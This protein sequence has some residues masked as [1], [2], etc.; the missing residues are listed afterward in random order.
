MVSCTM[1][2]ILFDM[3]EPVTESV[4]FT[5]RELKRNE[6]G[7]YPAHQT[8]GPDRGYW[9][10]E[11]QP[12]PTHRRSMRICATE[13]QQAFGVTR[14]THPHGFVAVLSDHPTPAG[15][16]LKPDAEELWQVWIQDA[17]SEP[18][19]VDHMVSKRVK[20]FLRR[21]GNK[22]AYVSIQQPDK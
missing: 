7:E 18:Y 12:Q 17:G 1:F 14:E 19:V 8:W 13:M 6:F 20:R 11:K 4:L 5:W 2:S 21:I 16:T 10:Q 9:W 3:S 15:R 22:R